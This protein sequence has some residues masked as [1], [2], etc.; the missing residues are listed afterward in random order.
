MPSSCQSFSNNE[1]RFQVLNGLLA[2][3]EGCPV[4][5]AAAGSVAGFMA[6]AGRST[7]TESCRWEVRLA[8]T[9]T[10]PVPLGVHVV[11]E[12]R[13]AKV[14]GTEPPAVRR[15]VRVLNDMSIESA[16]PVIVELL[17]IFVLKAFVIEVVAVC[18]EV[19]RIGR[20]RSADALNEREQEEVV[21]GI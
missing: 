16:G 5:V 13:I 3:L 6:S 10:A 7:N 2:F 12:R 17:I 1:L 9:V 18:D 21:L 15:P 14:D 4:A 8:R 11:E 20:L 19:I